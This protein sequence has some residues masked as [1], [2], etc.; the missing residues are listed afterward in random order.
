MK[1]CDY[2]NQDEDTS[3]R[4]SVEI[5][6]IFHLSNLNKNLIFNCNVYSLIVTN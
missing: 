6:I 5:A 1:N 2:L 4:K 3:P